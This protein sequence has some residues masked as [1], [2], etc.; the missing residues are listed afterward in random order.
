MKASVASRRPGMKCPRLEGMVY[1]SNCT[2]TL[3]KSFLAS[4]RSYP[5][6][7]EQSAM[8]QPKQGSRSLQIIR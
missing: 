7:L 3:Y 5:M 8:S 4:R 6:A 2:Q 1:G